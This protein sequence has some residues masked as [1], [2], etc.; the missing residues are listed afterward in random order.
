M[1]PIV[2]IG[3]AGVLAG[4]L[5][6]LNGCL[7]FLHPVDPHAGD[8]TALYQFSACAKD[9]VHIF[10]LNGLD[11]CH[12]GNLSGVRDY[13]HELGFRN[14]YYGQFFHSWLFASKMKQ[15]RSEDP[16]ARFVVVGF[17]AGAITSRTMVNELK[18][19][20]ITVDLLMY[21]GGATLQNVPQNRP[22]NAIKVV[23]VRGGEI[24]FRGW[25]I[26][27]AENVKLKDV[28][29]YGSPAHPETLRIL[30]RELI[31][32]AARVP[33][34]HRAL[35]LDSHSTTTPPS[36]RHAEEEEAWD[37][38]KVNFDYQPVPP[39]VLPQAPAART[40]DRPADPLP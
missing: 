20:G 12:L 37:F 8:T 16:H 2:R 23:H 3:Q 21:V 36:L 17:S 40:K 32:V 34:M 10:L 25:A 26:D 24:F 33:P 27:G 30:T 38:L 14:T 9:H 22:E 19:A 13:C 15:I 7:G 35:H 28:W 6:A 18:D 29:H 31:D 4:A 1:A 39:P 11:P 5:L